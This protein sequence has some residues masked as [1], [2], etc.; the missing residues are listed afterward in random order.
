[1]TKKNWAIIS[2]VIITIILISGYIVFQNFTKTP[3]FNP[4]RIAKIKIIVEEQNEDAFFQPLYQPPK[5]PKKMDGDVAQN[6]SKRREIPD[7]ASPLTPGF[8]SR[9]SSS[10]SSS[11]P[12]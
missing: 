10:G 4:E 2:I 9:S 6:I 7:A 5:Y 11:G 8:F 12:L 3:I 1:M